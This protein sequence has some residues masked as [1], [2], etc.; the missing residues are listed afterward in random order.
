MTSPSVDAFLASEAT[1]PASS[2]NGSS[3]M[4]AAPAMSVSSSRA[5]NLS[6]MWSAEAS[7][8]GSDASNATQPSASD[9]ELVLYSEKQ[10]SSGGVPM[11]VSASEGG[12]P[13]IHKTQTTTTTTT[14]TTPASLRRPL[15]KITTDPLERSYPKPEKDIDVGA[16]LAREPLK[17]SLG[18]WKKNA[19]DVDWPAP[20]PDASKQRF[21]DMKNEL[22]RAQLDMTVS[23]KAK[24]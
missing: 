15:N 4:L 6:D 18:H 23:S 5:S 9:L 19:R 13:Q 8:R 3:T 22:R 2:G 1:V 11:V 16:A 17:W 24:R 21:E 12:H 14:T 20:T 10:G 7:R